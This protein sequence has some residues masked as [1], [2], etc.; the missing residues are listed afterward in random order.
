MEIVWE[1]LG[2][3]P[4][5]MSEGSKAAAPLLPKHVD[6]NFCLIYAHLFVM[7]EQVQR[8]GTCEHRYSGNLDIVL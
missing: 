4:A 1:M 7:S 2:L 5:R 3:A 6:G 8:V